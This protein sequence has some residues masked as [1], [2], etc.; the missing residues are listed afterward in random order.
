MTHKDINVIKRDGTAVKFDIEKVHKILSFACENITGV[1]ISDI[2]HNASIQVANGTTTQDIHEILIKSASNLVT[3]HTPNYQYVAAR[4][5]NYQLRKLVY[6]QFEPVP[7]LDHVKKCVS[8]N[9]YDKEILEKYTDQE[10]E[11]LGTYIKH[12]RDNLF[13]YAAMEQWRGKYLVQNRVSKTYYETPQMAYMMIGATL[14]AN[15]PSETRLKYVKTFYDNVSTFNVSLPT[16]IMA[17]VR[18][19]TRQFSSCVVIN[20]GDDLNSINA[21]TDAIVKYI[22]KKAGIG[23]NMGQIRAIGSEINGGDAVHT[24]LIPFI[25]YVKSAV[26]SCSQG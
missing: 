6:N 25:K 12:N 22:S 16:P 15:Y 18:T 17:G 1:S 10:L 21:T 5:V 14:F 11:T 20:T 2:E 13:A 9:K 4:L 24:G 7:F 26:K 23:V 8:L 19:P 3:E